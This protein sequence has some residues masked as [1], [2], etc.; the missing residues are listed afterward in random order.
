MIAEPIS[1]TGTLSLQDTLD[2]N[3][4][5][6]RAIVRWPFRW[7][8]SIFSFLIATLCIWSTVTAGFTSVIIPL[9]L[10]CLYFPLGWLVERRFLAARRYRRH[11]ELYIEST[12]SFASDS[13][14]VENAN[15]QMRLNWNQLRSLLDT[16]RSRP[17]TQSSLLVALPAVR[18][19]QPESDDSRA[20]F[21]AQC[22]SH[23]NG[24]TRRCSERLPAVR[25]TFN[26]S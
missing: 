12:V 4:Y 7:I 11:P 13:V 16:P 19:Q 25:S 24:L 8:V 15:L 17:A 23:T 20:R 14:S 2:L 5:H 21:G 6:W 1:F 26:D 22:S 10:L 18:R 9:L 3:Y